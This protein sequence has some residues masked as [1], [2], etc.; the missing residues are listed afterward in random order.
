MATGQIE[1]VSADKFMNEGSTEQL[2]RDSVAR[3]Q[4][5][6]ADFFV[7]VGIGNEVKPGAL[8]GDNSSSF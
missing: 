8:L 3:A 6:C 1:A 7:T 5:P 2:I 4:L